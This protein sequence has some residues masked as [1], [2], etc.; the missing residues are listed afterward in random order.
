MLMA[1]TDR[2]MAL[3]S[4]WAHSWSRSSLV[5][6]QC[7][8]STKRWSSYK[9]MISLHTA[10]LLNLSIYL[11]ETSCPPPPQPLHMYRQTHTRAHTCM[12]TYTHTCVHA[13]THTHTHTHKAH[14]RTPAPKFKGV[15][16][17]FCLTEPIRMFNS[18]IVIICKRNNFHNQCAILPV[19]VLELI[20]P[21]L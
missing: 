12:H 20:E 21:K 16:V 9:H 5:S 14:T 17:F 8:L 6:P 19:S 15:C 2:P 13:W 10:T 3:K 1:G 7:I 4:N 18:I 11:L